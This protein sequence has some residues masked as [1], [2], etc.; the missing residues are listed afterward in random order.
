MKKV[1]LE[2]LAGILGDLPANPRL[3]VSGN[4]A[5]PHT[6]LGLADRT[7]ENYTLHMLNAQDGIPD[8]E[9]VTLE[10]CFVGPGM[11]HSPR[12]TYVPCRLSLVPVLFRRQLRPDAV[13]LHASAP[14]HDTVSLG[15][16]VNVLPA[17]IEAAREY[18]APVIVQSNPNM[19]YTYGD[20]QVY[21][22]EIDYL[23]EVEEP[24]AVHRPKHP[25]HIADQIGAII[26]AQVQDGSTLQMGIGAVP[27]AVLA[28]LRARRKL[29]I[30]TEMFSDGVL[31]LYRE[32]ALDDEIPL[33]S[34]FL[35]GSQD[36]YDFV[37]L[38]RRVRMLRTEVTN[39]P[40]RIARRPLMT[41]VN[42]A[43]QV[44][45][46]DQANSS[47]INGRIY[48]G[49]G[50]SVDFVVGALHS[51]GGAS[52]IALPSWHHKAQVSTIVPRLDEP[53]TSFQHSAVVTE[54]GMA[55]VWGLDQGAQARSIIENAAHPDA[56]AG[57]IDAAKSMG[58]V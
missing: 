57:L 24:L 28:H 22:H 54:Q 38:N 18:G 56:R 52:Y 34:S 50:G 1:S 26:A 16:E 48:S 7:L 2:Q 49:F 55:P 40:G 46:F 12:L 23:V 15:I 31:E 30:W 21:D 6:L 17:A 25:G 37:N 14:R 29:R 13:L 32:G 36:L 41:S 19:P 51:R 47:R 33:T 5:T 9:G 39:D 45:L 4:F 44:D 43:L 3:I 8:R 53:V 20:A 11:R 27:D 42:A 10:T 58:L 35:F